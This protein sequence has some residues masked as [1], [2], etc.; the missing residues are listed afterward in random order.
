MSVMNK[1]GRSPSN[2]RLNFMS[3]KGRPLQMRFRRETRFE[4]C[5][6]V[7]APFR[8]PVETRLE[9]L[10]HSL[11]QPVLRHTHNS[12]LGSRLKS[13]LEAYNLAV[14]SLE[15]NVLVKARK[16]KEYQAAN[17]GEEIKALEPIDRVPRML[18]AA[19]LTDGLPFESG[20]D[21]EVVEE[22]VEGEAVAVRRREVEIV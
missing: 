6:I 12:E 5:P 14:G 13:S 10:K 4:V 16:F 21:P 1:T 11:L 7:T 18:Q 20:D 15:G 19:E 2:L 9:Q 3:A 8:G 22:V 17:G